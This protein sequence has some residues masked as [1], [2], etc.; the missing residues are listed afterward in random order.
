MYKIAQSE[1]SVLALARDKQAILATDDGQAIKACK[2][3]GLKFVTAIHFLEEHTEQSQAARESGLQWC[4]PW[5]DYNKIN[6][7]KSQF[8]VVQ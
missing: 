4:M 5:L 6:A 8:L 2:I 3:F 1:A 7:A